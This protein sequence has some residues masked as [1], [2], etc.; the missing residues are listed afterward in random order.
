MVW[1]STS[2]TPPP[3]PPLQP[4]PQPASPPP[5]PPQPPPLP[6]MPPSQPMEPNLL[7]AWH[8]LTIDQLAWEVST[9][10]GL[11]PAPIAA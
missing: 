5:E 4:P 7:V 11:I 9:R 10:L 6:H 8:P 2:C 3:A 1:T